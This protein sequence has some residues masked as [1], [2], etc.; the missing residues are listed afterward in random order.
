MLEQT[1]RLIDVVRCEVQYR[2][3]PMDELYEAVR[4]CGEFSLLGLDRAEGLRELRFPEEITEAR[5]KQLECFFQ[6]IGCVGTEETCRQAD[7][8]YR[9]CGA[10]IQAAKAEALRAARL[11]LPAGVCIGMLAAIMLV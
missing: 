10:Y 4:A 9:L 8:Y 3:L 11:E 2:A 5:R 1:E 6:G 7:Y